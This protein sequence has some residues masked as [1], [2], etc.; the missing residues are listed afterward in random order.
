MNFKYLFTGLLTGILLISCG[1]SK[2]T[3]EDGSENDSPSL[4][5]AVSG[6]KNLNKLADA[7]SDT[8]KVQQKLAKTTPLSNDQMKALLPETLYGMERSRFSVGSAMTAGMNMAEAD[9][10][11]E[12]EKS[13]NLTIVDGAGETGAGLISG[14]LM[15]LSMEREEQTESGF[16][17]TT[18]IGGYRASV[19]ENKGDGW[20]NSEIIVIV[21][22]RYMITLSSSSLELKELEK[23][24]QAL[25]LNKMK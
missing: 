1:G 21:S 7:A 6:L 13:I 24:F 18:T 10:S 12:Q 4:S 19:K 17:K 16:S 14:T 25:D 2:S 5:E 11:K 20:I 9:Y 23:A 8:E 15:A 3:K 22:D